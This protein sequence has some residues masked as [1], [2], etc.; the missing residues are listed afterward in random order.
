M[1]YLIITVY[2]SVLSLYVSAVSLSL[3]IIHFNSTIII[4]TA[5][6]YYTVSIFIPGIAAVWRPSSTPSPIGWLTW[7]TQFWPMRRRN[8]NQ[9]RPVVCVEFP[10]CWRCWAGGAA[11]QRA[12]TC[13]AVSQSQTSIQTSSA[14]VGRPCSRPVDRNDQRGRCWG[15]GPGSSSTQFESE[16]TSPVAA[17][18]PKQ[19]QEPTKPDPKSAPACSR[20]SW[21]VSTSSSYCRTRARFLWA[22]SDLAVGAESWN[23]APWMRLENRDKMAAAAGV[24]CARC[25]SVCALW[26]LLTTCCCKHE[27]PIMEHECQEIAMSRPYN[28]DLSGAYS[29]PCVENA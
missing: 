3:I 19:Q 8:T 27:T 12:L 16:P 24:R 29:E 6:I 13:G 25:L 17:S 11:Q 4:N 10:P 7:Q 28:A 5:E 21:R 20:P 22:G 2:F 23:K 15:A 1:W 18:A 14:Q 26:R 9:L